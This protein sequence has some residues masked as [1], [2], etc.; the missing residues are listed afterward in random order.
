MHNLEIREDGTAAFLAVR[1]PGWHRL[2]TVMPDDVTMQEALLIAGMRYEYSLAPV[3]VDVD[4]AAVQVS[5]ERQAVLRRN[6]DVPEDIKAFGGGLS[7]RFKPHSLLDLWGWAEDLLGHGA[8]VETVG[9]LKDGAHSFATIKL[10]GDALLGDEK[11]QMY[12]TVS[13]GH[14]GTRATTATVSP[15]RVVCSN[16]LA[17]SDGAAKDKKAK[18]GH[19]VAL[20]SNDANQ[21]AQILGIM[22][23][24]Q[25]MTEAVYSTLKAVTLRQE[26][27]NDILKQLFVMPADL[28]TKPYSDMTTGEKRKYSIVTQSRR[29]VDDLMQTSPYRAQ[30]SDG[31]SLWNAAVEWSDHVQSVKGKDQEARRAERAL[32]GMSDS[33]KTKAFDLIVA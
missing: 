23:E 28:V 14:D 21:T 18:V 22:R 26:D 4:G 3:F 2:G 33:F 31:W 15:I 11:T 17:F 6:I 8:T 24:Q 9:N 1:T 25:D 20:D 29:E 19:R 13:T 7:T 5:G 30:G 27:V 32:M 16:T 12:L 10:P